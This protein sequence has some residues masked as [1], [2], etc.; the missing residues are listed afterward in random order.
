LL[1]QAPK[2][3]RQVPRILLK[4][5]AL[6]KESLAGELPFFGCGDAEWLGFSTLGGRQTK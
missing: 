2:P 1:A 4:K 5:S 6:V 3:T